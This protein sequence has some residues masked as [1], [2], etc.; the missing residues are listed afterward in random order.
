MTVSKI[1]KKERLL[2][3]D[4]TLDVGA[5][6]LSKGNRI[7]T[8]RPKTATLLL[9]LARTAPQPVSRD[10][11]LAQ[12]WPDVW[13]SDESLTGA[14]AELRRA[15]GQFGRRTGPVETVQKLGYRL[16]LPAVQT[17]QIVPNTTK[18]EKTRSLDFIEA[19]LACNEA[20]VIREKH[21]EWAANAA[22]ELC[23]EAARMAPDFAM[24]QAEFALSAADCRLYAPEGFDD[25]TAAFAAADT[26]VQLRP[27][28]A[29]GYMARGAL[30]DAA[31]DMGAACA[32]YSQ[33][34]LID[35]TDAECHLLLARA[36]Y[37]GGDMVR[38]AR[39]ADVAATLKPTDYRPLYLAAG[40]LAAIGDRAGGI[41]AAKQ[42]LMRLRK[43][44]MQDPSEE[45]AQ[46][47]KGSLLAR[48][49]RLVEAVDAMSKYEKS[50][51]RVTYYNV[52]TLGW[53][54][55]VDTALDRLEETIEGG[56]RNIRWAWRDPALAPLRRESRFAKMLS[57]FA[58]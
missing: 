9:A 36:L 6:Q 24:I 48:A 16:T 35:P 14:V 19:R 53:A 23:Q 43:Y 55:E 18:I 44:D 25:L 1:S 39:V 5:R 28:Q 4:W 7:K 31:G 17:H 29:A 46:N 41:K 45:R 2:I 10:D 51:G 21:G 27:D 15:F 12:V 58:T 8:L 40:A 37:A 26:A 50:G 56:F 52:A 54:G 3:G 30:F 47:I 22:L 49:G 33:A 38:A 20:R 13:V 34:I 42:G 11:L 32:N 57:G